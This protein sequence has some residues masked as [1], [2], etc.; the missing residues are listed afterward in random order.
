MKAFFFLQ[1]L[2]DVI[3]SFRS[4]LHLSGFSLLLLDFKYERFFSDK[5]LI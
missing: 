2:G 5:V 1:S 4:T 3:N